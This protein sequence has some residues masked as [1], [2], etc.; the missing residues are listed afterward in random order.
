MGMFDRVLRSG[1]GKKVRALA[2][3]VPDIN[4]LEPEFERLSDD[5][6][7]AKSPEFRQRL[8][9]GADVDDVLIEA[10]AVMREG[11]KRTT[12]ANL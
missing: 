6:L 8:D 11:A 4:A 3:L 12:D 1:E 2:G 10:F 7:A 5:A 9:N